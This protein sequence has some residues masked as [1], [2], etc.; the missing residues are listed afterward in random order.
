MQRWMVTGLILTLPVVGRLGAQQA[1]SMAGASRT[2]AGFADAWNKHDMTAFGALFADDADFVNVAGSWWHGRASIQEH[3]AFAHGTLSSADTAGLG[4]PARLY[5][6]FRNSTIT[7]D[8]TEMRL[9]RP[10][11]A[12][13]RVKWHLVGDARTSA[14]R[15]GRLLFVLVARAGVW[16]IT[17]AQNTEFARTVH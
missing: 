7:F 14:A 12:L 4:A 6:I 13:A 9:V 5:G 8:S 2:V 17:A 3:H 15:T 11:V 10:D 16:H 1:P